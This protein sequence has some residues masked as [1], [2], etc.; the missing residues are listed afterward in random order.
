MGVKE[1][2]QV[3]AVLQGLFEQVLDEEVENNHD[4]LVARAKEIMNK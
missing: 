3:G 2:K 4:A 1:G